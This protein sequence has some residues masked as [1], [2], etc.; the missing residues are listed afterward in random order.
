MRW[1]PILTLNFLATLLAL[2]GLSRPISAQQYIQI[3]VE[4]TE[5]TGGIFESGLRSGLRTIPDVRVVTS[6]EEYDYLLT[7]IVICA[8]GNCDE[9]TFYAVSL[10]L[11]RPLHTEI[12]PV[13]FPEEARSDTTVSEAV[14]EL[15]E[16]LAGYEA[17]LTSR[18]AIWGRDAYRSAIREFVGAIDTSC[19]EMHR[20]EMRKTL[21][22][23]EGNWDEVRRIQRARD[24]RFREY[25]LDC[26]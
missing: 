12:I 23:E 24:S 15:M 8:E 6:A 19:F 25:G 1:L 20:M 10:R 5:D 22:L 11:S 4:V 9:T 3:A 7:A 13:F 2:V 18:V 14:S 17:H 26:Y 16:W 21:A